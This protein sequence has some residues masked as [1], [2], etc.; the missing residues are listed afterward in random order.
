MSVAGALPP[1]LSQ[2]TPRD[3]LILWLI[4]QI[5]NSRTTVPGLAD[6]HLAR[7]EISCECPLA[8]HH[9]RIPR[10]SGTTAF[11]SDGLASRLLT[12][13]PKVNTSGPAPAPSEAGVSVGHTRAHTAV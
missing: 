9:G 2:R 5:K 11:G 10:R 4:A 8:T 3:G 7:A 12:A 6:N 1:P 13:G